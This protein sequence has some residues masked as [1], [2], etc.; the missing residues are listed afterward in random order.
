MG[1][2]LWLRPLLVAASLLA[3]AAVAGAPD[4]G[5]TPDPDAAVKLVREQKAAAYAGVLARFDASMR[6]A[7]A[8]AAIAVARCRFISNFVDEEYGEWVDAA[9]TQYEECLKTIETRWPKEPVAQMFGL[10]QL[11]GE[12][13]VE[14]GEALVK[15]ADHWPLPLRRELLTKVSEAQAGES[16]D[17]R[18]GELAVA[19]T[20]LGEQSRVAAAAK[21]LA[22]HG[23][24][25]EA[26][27]ML[28]STP[29]AGQSW[30][31]KA[32]IEAAMALP[33]PKAGLRE[34]R[35]YAG[36]TFDVD[37]DVAARAHLRAGDAAS[38]RKLLADQT[39][40]SASV[41]KLRFDIA[42]A[43]KDFTAAAALVDLTDTK[44]LYAN[45]ERFG[46]LAM[47][48]PS[49]LW[50]RP[51]LMGSL[52]MLLALLALALTPGLLLVPAHYRGLIRRA[53]GK[54]TVPLFDSIGLRHAWYGGFV[55][56]CVPMM[57]GLVLEPRA[58]A[59]MLEGTP[60]SEPVALFRMMLWGTVLGL[61][62]VLPV[63]RAMGIR[64]V[65]GDRSTLR[66]AGWVLLAWG[67]LILVSVLNSAWNGNAS[68]GE[69][70]HTRAMAA[71]AEGG[72]EAY[73]PW[74]TVLLVAVFG[75]VLEELTFRGLILGGLSRHISFG[76][77]NTLQAAL[78]AMMHDDPPRLPF[79][80]A[81]GLLAGWLA[82]KSRSLGP[83]IALH[84]LNNGLAFV[85]RML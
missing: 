35:R 16:N 28:Q 57:A 41:Q 62:C 23:R 69:T 73:G 72:R 4:V 37:S 65:L 22:G 78:F 83:A 26:A 58:M 70:V 39:Y 82:R 40:K 3:G 17:E 18:A 33:D 48:A 11:W 67:V 43:A 55:A 10:T 74:V 12:E 8:D 9:P 6:A 7:P 75:P 85:M 27:R 47:R 68:S 14:Q 29:P 13:A 52:V 38:A 49:T 59:Q 21:Y 34:L 56:I 20:R 46:T 54:T 79:Y 66:S 76:W 42:M 24:A 15:A 45:I 2:R 81:L 64:Q 71:L 36:A 77:A 80:F 84:A 1:M 44:D 51:M 61:V 25:D 60:V 31:A 63:V 50:S 19:A 30:Q 53:R 5:A 32:R